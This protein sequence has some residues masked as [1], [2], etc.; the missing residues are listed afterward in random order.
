[1]DFEKLFLYTYGLTSNHNKIKSALR[2]T[3]EVLYLYMLILL[4]KYYE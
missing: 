1:M 4:H 3:F 2:N